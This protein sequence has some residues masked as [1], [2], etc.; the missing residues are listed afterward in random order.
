MCDKVH[1]ANRVSSI[2]SRRFLSLPYHR[3]IG[4]IRKNVYTGCVRARPPWR[5]P[6]VRG[7]VLYLNN[8]AITVIV[9]YA[10]S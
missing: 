10:I 4:R 1:I 9:N 5:T 6:T 2:E 3:P 7:D 8:P